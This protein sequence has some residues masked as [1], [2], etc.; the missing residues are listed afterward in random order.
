MVSFITD[1]HQINK[2]LVINPHP[3]SRIGKTIEQLEGFHYAT[4]LYLNMGYY[5]IR[6]FP[7]SQDMMT[8]ITKF[9][10]F[11]H[12]GLPM[13]MCASVDIFKAKVHV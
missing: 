12:N 10:K 1:Y 7:A 5:N 13:G 8:I 3:S 4:T 11:C 6:I 2:Q 9:G